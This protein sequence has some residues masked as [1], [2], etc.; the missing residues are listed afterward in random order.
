MIDQYGRNINYLRLSVTERCTLRCVYCRADEGICPKAAELSCADFLRIARACVDLG[1]RRIRVTGGEPLLRKD[2]L[3][4]VGGLGQI[5]ELV[6]LTM[7]TNA[8]YLAEHAEGLKKA[9]LK[10]INIS[11]D[12]LREDR[13]RQI[14]GGELKNVLE[15]IDAAVN[16]DL[17]PIKINVVL[18]RGVNDDEVDDFIAL[19]RD[20][21]LDVRMIELMPVGV[22][23]QDESLRINNDEL[24]AARPYLQPVAPSYSGQPSRDYKITG[25]Q[26]RVGFISPISHSFCADCN[27]IR[28][29]SDG[30]LRPCLGN[31]AEI[32]LKPALQEGDDALLEVIR[33]TIFNKPMRHHFEK[34]FSS[35]KS[36]LK[37]G[38]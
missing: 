37:I 36:M 15:G 6:D 19:T 31:N 20:N 5:E 26:G 10:R 1:I 34:G 17:L 21:P 2:I 8:Q 35:E 22:L 13:Y 24:I 14:T 25:H 9:G 12:S 16:A 33:S 23:G 32:S 29:M 11:L 18:V 38:G 3:E 4:I 28:V 7:T 30:M 27:R